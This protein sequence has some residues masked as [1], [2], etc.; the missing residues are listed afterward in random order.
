MLADERHLI[1]RCDFVF[2]LRQNDDPSISA[3]RFSTWCLVIGMHLDLEQ[4]DTFFRQSKHNSIECRPSI[5]R[6]PCSF[7][8]VFCVEIQ[9]YGHLLSLYF[10]D[11]V[12]SRRLNCPSMVRNSNWHSNFQAQYSHRGEDSAHRLIP[13]PHGRHSYSLGP[14]FPSSWGHKSAICWKIFP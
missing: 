12:S 6:Q 11:V 7:M 9:Y 5:R 8:D 3:E 2:L 13:G 1:P 4:R 14:S 10:F